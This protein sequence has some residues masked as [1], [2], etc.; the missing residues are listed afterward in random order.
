MAYEYGQY[1]FS[2]FKPLT[3]IKTHK[4]NSGGP[5]I[6]PS[7]VERAWAG[8]EQKWEEFLL[9]WRGK[10]KSQG[11][12][13]YKGGRGSS[14]Y[15]TDAWYAG[16]L[17]DLANW[18]NQQAAQKSQKGLDQMYSQWDTKFADYNRQQDQR[19]SD[20]TSGNDQ[21]WS[22]AMADWNIEKTYNIGG[23]N[24]TTGQAFQRFLDQG[25]S[26]KQSLADMSAAW[27]GSVA[28]LNKQMGG[29][30]DSLQQQF[31]QQSAM[32]QGSTQQAQGVQGSSRTYQ[33]YRGWGSTGSGFNRK[34][35]RITNLNI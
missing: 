18:R 33:P 28:G 19:F 10:A 6:G 34:G 5:Y 35:L 16:Q 29:L 1:D 26:N 14:G 22:D 8:G 21:R 20:F 9:D 4:E 27:Q 31:A 15:N 32:N 24:L 23:E 12:E 3:D 25:Q 17:Q 30:H 11:N 2:T 7:H 13:N